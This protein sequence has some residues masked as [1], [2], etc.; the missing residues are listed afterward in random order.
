MKE[1]N[2]AAPAQDGWLQ[3]NGLLYRLSGDPATNWD[4]INVTMADGS[5]SIESR[6]RRAGELLDRIRSITAPAQP[7][8]VQP[9]R[10]P[11]RDFACKVCGS[12]PDADGWLEHGS[13]CYTR[14][15]NGGGSEFIPDAANTPPAAPVQP[16]Q[17][18]VAD[19]MARYLRVCSSGGM[20]KKLQESVQNLVCDAE[21]LGYFK[22][23][24]PPAAQRK[25]LTDE[26]QREG[27]RKQEEE[28]T[29]REMSAWQVWR[30]ACAW[31]EAAHN[32]KEKNT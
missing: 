8:P 3:A 18:P 12:K 6:T 25:P 19:A 28:W 22:A 1:A 30:K 5:R 14:S 23:T 11:V 9:E 21:R 4:E 20:P 32:I 17:E 7:A 16:E 15:E 31:T 13:G 29:F 2:S 10:E 24:T 26:Q 27:F